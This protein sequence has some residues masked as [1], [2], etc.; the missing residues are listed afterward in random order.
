M[1]KHIS[2][3]HVTQSL[4][5]RMPS[6][7]IVPKAAAAEIVRARVPITMLVVEGYVKFFASD[8]MMKTWIH[9]LFGDDEVSA[10]VF[11]DMFSSLSD[12]KITEISER[13]SDGKYFYIV[14]RIDGRV[15]FHLSDEEARKK[16]ENETAESDPM[17]WVIEALPMT[18]YT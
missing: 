4:T 6:H 18:I 5:E 11:Q 15:S 9:E 14:R 13:I 2:P 1:F 7:T 3:K 16:I 8:E 10:D 12:E 17:G